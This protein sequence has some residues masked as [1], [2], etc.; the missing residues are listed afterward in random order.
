MDQS[1]TAG[2]S[3]RAGT[4]DAFALKG[5][6]NNCRYE[7]KGNTDHECIEAASHAHFR[8]SLFLRV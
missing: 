6:K 3:D 8:V 1:I 4:A 5:T 7:D 2:V